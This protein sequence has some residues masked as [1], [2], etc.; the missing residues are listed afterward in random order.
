MPQSEKRK[1]GR[2]LKSKGERLRKAQEWA[3]EMYPDA[4]KVCKVELVEFSSE[5]GLIDAKKCEAHGNIQV[6]FDDIIKPDNAHNIS[7][8]FTEPV[9]C[10]SHHPE[11]EEDLRF[12]FELLYIPEELSLTQ[13]QD[14]NIKTLL[15]IKLFQSPIGASLYRLHKG[16]HVLSTSFCSSQ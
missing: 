8:I 2:V 11:R 9:I 4:V 5:N 12:Q 16:S 10:I 7:T 15:K 6:A 14:F 1:L 13:V 3:N